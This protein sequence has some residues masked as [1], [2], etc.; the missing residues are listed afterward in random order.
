MCSYQKGDSLL[1]M[2]NRWHIPKELEEKIRKRDKICVYCHKVFGENPKDRAEWEHIDNDE[3]N[4][5]KKNIALCCGSCNRSKGAKSLKEW[6]K[7]DYCNKHS[8]SKSSL[9]F[10]ISK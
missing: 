3:N 8:I 1:K 6:L 5:T 7:S 4:I 2:S 9:A 10:S